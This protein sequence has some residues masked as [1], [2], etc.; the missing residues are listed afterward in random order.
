MS[1]GPKFPAQTAKF[2]F[3]PGPESMYYTICTVQF[4]EILHQNQYNY[5]KLLVQILYCPS[6]TVMYIVQYIV[7]H[8]YSM[9]VD[10]LYLY[11]NL[12]VIYVH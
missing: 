11:T 5:I 12:Y 10:V 4:F 7:V 8:L 6:T 9:Y 2:F 3:R 1:T